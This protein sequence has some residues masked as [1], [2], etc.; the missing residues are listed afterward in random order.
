[1]LTGDPSGM[2]PVW[3]EGRTVVTENVHWDLTSQRPYL[4]PWSDRSMALSCGSL[5]V[6]S[7]CSFTPS[8]WE[9]MLAGPIR[10]QAVT[11]KPAVAQASV[12]SLG[13][14][15]TAGT[16]ALEMH[17]KLSSWSHFSFYL[18][19]PLE[20]CLLVFVYLHVGAVMAAVDNCCCYYGE[21]PTSSWPV[22]AAPAEGSLESR[23]GLGRNIWYCL[24]PLPLIWVISPKGNN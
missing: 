24:T 22:V 16:S 5:L 11:D 3:R 21:T 12:S 6:E 9:C 7:S 2:C 13:V 20:C 15:I 8:W 18:V 14:W 1:M 23:A 19:F 4:N 17:I 10:R